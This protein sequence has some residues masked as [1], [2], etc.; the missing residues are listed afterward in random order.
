MIDSAA[1]RL[2]ELELQGLTGAAHG[3]RSPDRLVQ[4][5]GYRDRAALRGDLRWS[6][7]GASRGETRGWTVVLR[8]PRLRKGSHFPGVLEPRRVPEIDERVRT[9]LE[10]PIEARS[11]RRQNTS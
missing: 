9:F 10:R 8:I 7:L 5:N 11:R 4:R 2:M 1:E 3:E 6:S